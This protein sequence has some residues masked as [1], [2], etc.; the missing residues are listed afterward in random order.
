MASL[1]LPR[2]TGFCPEPEANPNKKQ[3]GG[4]EEERHKMP[5]CVLK[6][7]VS[8]GNIE[9]RCDFSPLIFLH[10]NPMH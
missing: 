8:C 6:R 1:S 2:R 5:D 3:S 10:V 7:Q 4:N 9:S